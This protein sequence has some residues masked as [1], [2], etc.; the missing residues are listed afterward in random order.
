MKN[1]AK[2][3]TPPELPLPVTPGT[4]PVTGAWAS[5]TQILA[6][7]PFL[8]AHVDETFLRNRAREINPRTSA[9]WIP[10]PRQNQFE[11][12]PT[13]L[14][15]LEWF[16][17]K[18]T[19]RDGLPA[20]YDS[21][22]AMENS[23]LRTP[24]EFTKWS[25]KNGAATAQL[26]GS[27]INPRPV[28]EKAASILRLIPTGQV[29]GVEGFEEWN[30]NTE[31]AQKLRQERMKLEDEALLRRGQMMMSRDG[32]FALTELQVDELIWDLRD[33]PLRA[34]LVKLDKQIN[35]QHK[36]ILAAQSPDAS[37]ISPALASVTTTAVQD[38][39]AKLRQKLPP[40]KTAE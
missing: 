29:K 34:A 4:K 20:S 24:K 3:N 5:A 39:L 25:L 30:T 15:L 37:R 7:L 32:S 13:I 12:N 1:T 6:Q 8:A 36:N 31:L 2:N 23:F 35:R 21:M 10:K 19:A 11:I 16:A 38:L 28:L 9:P 14:G 33:Q 22:Q 26:G 40:K 18:A 17:A 27:R